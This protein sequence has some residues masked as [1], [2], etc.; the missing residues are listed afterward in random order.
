M[1]FRTFRGYVIVMNDFVYSLSGQGCGA[2]SLKMLLIALTRKSG[3]RFIRIEEEKAPSLTELSAIALKEGVELTWKRVQ[4]GGALL[5]NREFPLLLVLNRDEGQTHM[6]LLKKKKG[7]RFL[8][9]DPSQG[10]CHVEKDDLIRRWTGIYGVSRVIEKK[11][12]PYKRKRIARLSVLLPSFLCSLLGSASLF[13]A[14]FF[15]SDEGNF[16]CPILLFAAYALFAVMERLLTVKAMKRFDRKYLPR[17]AK[18]KRSRLKES[19]TRYHSFKAAFFMSAISMCRGAMTVLGLC[20][21]LG[22]NEPSFLVSVAAL[23]LFQTVLFIIGKRR[24]IARES[25]LEEMEEALFERDASSEERAL[26]I[27]AIA[28]E[29]YRIGDG[30]SYLRIVAIAMMM[31]LGL[32]PVFYSGTI[33]LN[34]YLFHLFGLIGIGDGF[35]SLLAYFGQQTLQERDE[36]YFL[37]YFDGPS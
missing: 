13:A 30:Y 27:R 19:F 4:D 2:A 26:A 29:S 12:C 34:F 23:C 35:H 17:L 25:R 9:Y 31:V 36:A 5:S 18:I 32:F 10:K 20:F 8:I 11:K 37:A 33:A 7:S 16:L 15:M 14:F 21:L 1:H 28:E 6:V 22:I 24:F 3:Y